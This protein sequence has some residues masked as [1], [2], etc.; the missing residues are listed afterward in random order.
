MNIPGIP[1]PPMKI[2]CLVRHAK[3]GRDDP[4]LRD[5]DRPLNARGKKQAPWLGRR[6]KGSSVQPGVIISSPAKRA[7]ATAE[8]LAGEI[9]YPL[10]EII[11]EPALYESGAPAI[12]GVIKDIA[13]DQ[14]VA[15]VVGHNPALSDLMNHLSCRELDELPVAGIVC[16]KFDGDSWKKIARGKGEV[17]FYDAPPKEK[18]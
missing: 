3:A 17:L 2:V 16:L 11:T 6:L 9:Q 4:S 18:E 13:E 14:D 8:T 7:I 5:F 10:E 1:P 15:V 12:L